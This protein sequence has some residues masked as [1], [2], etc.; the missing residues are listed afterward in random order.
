[1]TSNIVTGQFTVALTPLDGYAK[2]QNGI[3][4]GRMS[5]DK[6][7][8]GK[9]NASSQGEM[10]SAMTPVQGSAGYVAIEQVI[11][12]LEGKKGSFVLQH[13]GTMD[14]GQDSLILNVISDSGTDELEGLAGSMK[15]RIE[16]GVHYYD[17]QYTL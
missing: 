3:N 4:L 7:F 17:F 10:L 12:E 5:I 13:F 9:L 1:M 14:K 15:I 8:T 2:G 11:G 6:T 16:N